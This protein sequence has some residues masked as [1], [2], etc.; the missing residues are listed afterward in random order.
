MN[1][2]GASGT[3]PIFL[4]TDHQASSAMGTSVSDGMIRTLFCT[5]YQHDHTAAH[6]KVHVDVASTKPTDLLCIYLQSEMESDAQSMHPNRHSDHFSNQAIQT[7]WKWN[8]IIHRKEHIWCPN[9]LQCILTCL[10]VSL[11]RNQ[12]N[13]NM[14]MCGM[15]TA[16]FSNTCT[17]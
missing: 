13:L 3:Q 12:T 2:A 11:P 15:S 14:G 4:F 10:S 17:C 16:P 7:V 5:A 8:G 6:D 9:V 1:D